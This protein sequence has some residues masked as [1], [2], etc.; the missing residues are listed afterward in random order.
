MVSKSAAAKKASAKEVKDM[1]K[2]RKQEAKER[3]KQEK[4][5]KQEEMRM[6]RISMGTMNAEE[7]AHRAKF[8]SEVGTEER[9]GAARVMAKKGMPK[10]IASHVTKYL[11]PK[12]MP[13]KGTWNDLVRE[14][15]R[16]NPHL[17]FGDA[18]K[19]AS[20]SYHK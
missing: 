15:R 20:K 10:G 13:A 9:E 17:S 11:K 3:A 8:E 7:K 19:L 2:L 4:G 18:L 16:Q 12:P 6:N 5:I 1:A 14:T